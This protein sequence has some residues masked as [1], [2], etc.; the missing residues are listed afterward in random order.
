MICVLSWV[1]ALLPSASVE[2]P[3]QSAAAGAV[4]H[5]PAPRAVGAVGAVGAHRESESLLGAAA[6]HTDLPRSRKKAR[7]RWNDLGV[8]PAAAVGSKW[9]EA[10]D[11]RIDSI[12]QLPSLCEIP[13]RQWLKAPRQRVLIR[14]TL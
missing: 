11:Q 1:C 12:L 14:V 10:R 7:I 9:L 6:G 8:S 2:L 3:A 13:A 5:A 4:P